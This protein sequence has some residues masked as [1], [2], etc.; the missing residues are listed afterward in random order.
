MPRRSAPTPLRLVTGPLPRRGLPRHTLPSVPRP[1]F[2]PPVRLSEGP[3]PRERAHTFT[4]EPAS[5]R[6]EL[7]PVV[8][9]LMDAASSPTSSVSGSSDGRRS[10]ASWESARSSGEYAHSQA[11]SHSRGEYSH[12]RSRSRGSSID[13]EGAESEEDD[14]PRVCGPWE[15]HARAF[16]LPV[17]VNVVVTPPRPVAIN[18]VPVW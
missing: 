6:V 15:K 8:H 9:S 11:R 4:L 16:S 2:H 7:A 12:A 18:P 1:A 3:V 17:D 14:V 5:G 10:R 13:G